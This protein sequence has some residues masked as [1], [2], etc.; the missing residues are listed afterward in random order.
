V[1][2]PFLAAE[3]AVT[4]SEFSHRALVTRHVTSKSTGMSAAVFAVVSPDVARFECE[5][6]RR[7]TVVAVIPLDLVSEPAWLQYGS[8]V[9][10]LRWTLDGRI[11]LVTKAGRT[12]V[13][14]SPD[15]D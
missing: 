2:D 12:L 1:L 7:R 6:R 11:E 14:P 9:T 4:T 15:I 8:A 3:R 10:S 13:L 5:I